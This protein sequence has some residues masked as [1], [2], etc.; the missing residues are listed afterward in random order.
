MLAYLK[1]VK[2]DHLFLIALAQIAIKYGLFEPF[3]IPIT[4]NAFGLSLLIIATLC[5]VAAGTI[6]I[7]IY[8]QSNP[9]FEVLEGYKIL[10]KSANRLFIILNAMGVLIGF[11][12]SHM[13]GQPN[14]AVLFVLGSALFYMYASYL[15]EILILKNITIAVLASMVIVLVGIYD[16]IPAITDDNRSSLSVI[17]SIIWDYAIFGG[18]MVW[19]RELVK[20][21]I[22]LDKDHNAGLST[23]PI[24]LGKDRTTQWIGMLSFIPLAGVIYYIYRYLFSNTPAVLVMLFCVVAPLLFF[25]ISAFG[26]ETEKQLKKLKLILT[27]ILFLAT[28]TLFLYQFLLPS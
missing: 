4:L 25:I 17:F 10:A 15:K 8:N 20:D 7:E 23:L 24:V 6:I 18:M 13:V 1:L 27:I 19:L 3:G 11:Y 26:A 12:I 14:F 5:I 9:D 28:V 2:I 22:N 21:C 16:L